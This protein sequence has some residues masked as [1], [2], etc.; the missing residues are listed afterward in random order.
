M[1]LVL[2][3]K[4]LEALP[5]TVTDVSVEVSETNELRTGGPR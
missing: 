1:A 5:E 4:L 2:E 3:R